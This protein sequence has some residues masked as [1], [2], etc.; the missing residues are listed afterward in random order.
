MNR[1]GILFI[2]SAPSGA[3]KT[4][5]CSRLQNICSGLK[6]SVSYTTRNPRQGEIDGVHYFFVK[7]KNFNKMISNGEFAE[8]AKVHD[9]L[10]GTSKGKIDEMVTQGFDVLLDID[11]Q[12]GKQIK[13]NIPDSVQIFILPPN[14]K[15]LE[16]RLRNRMSDSEDIILRRISRAQVEIE[17]Y[18]RYDYVIVNNTLDEALFELK[19]IVLAERAKVS[20]ADHK[21]IIKNFL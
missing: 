6:I 11:V 16:E 18:K 10:Y 7:E 20:R 21:W 13:E 14:M 2:I 4:T 17:E 9:N 5:L 12:G 8:W 15:V 19:S 1:K 3:G